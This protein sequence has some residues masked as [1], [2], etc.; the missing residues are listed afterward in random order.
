MKVILCTITGSF[1]FAVVAAAAC[2]QDAAGLYAEG[3]YNESI[4]GDLESAMKLYEQAGSITTDPSIAARVALRL[5]NCQRKLGRMG[6]AR[7]KYNRII[8]EF[9]SQK[10]AVKHAKLALL[11]LGPDEQELKE[12]SGQLKAEVDRLKS[13]LKTVDSTIAG[14]KRE[15]PGGPEKLT[16]EGMR[17]FEEMITREEARQNVKSYLA[18]H[19]FRTGLLAYRA[20]AYERALEDFK[21]AFSLSPD[22]KLVRGYLEKTEFIL[23]RRGN[24]T[25]AAMKD[26]A[27]NPAPQLLRELGTAYKMALEARKKGDYRMALAAV[28]EILA[29]VRWTNDELVTRDIKILLEKVDTLAEEC[30]IRLY[31]TESRR[32]KELSEER[33]VLARKLKNR[34][35]EMLAPAE[36]QDSLAV[37]AR[38]RELFNAGKLPDAKALLEKYIAQAGSDKEVIELLEEINLAVRGEKKTSQKEVL[39]NVVSAAVALAAAE[40][41]SLKIPFRAVRSPDEGGVP[42]VSALVGAG[43]G[44]EILSAAA[45]LGPKSIGKFHKMEVEPGKKGSG[46]L[47]SS[48][49]YISGYRKKSGTEEGYEPVKDIVFRGIKLAVMPV[50][51]GSKI[52]L[53]VEISISVIAGEPRVIQTEGG[54]VEIPQVYKAELKHTFQCNAGEYLVLGAFPNTLSPGGEKRKD[55]MYI[56]ISPKEVTTVKGEEEES[57]R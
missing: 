49:T 36:V 11:A 43:K 34:L 46:F 29:R 30:L 5:G 33:N 40:L 38:A 41:G 56:V 51:D 18:S 35:D 12:W 15:L 31:P 6:F 16:K 2:A 7:E 19:Y 3:V 45:L 17:A 10:N 55:D 53:T 13:V 24:L 4:T 57:G 20:L 28:E 8:N 23:G 44:K 22:D 39:Y 27:D 48:M 32:L 14:L 50:A 9:A 26:A 21:A 42:F 37:T 52:S 47:G 1:L 54:R 25:P